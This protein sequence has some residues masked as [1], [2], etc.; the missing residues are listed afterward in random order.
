MVTEQRVFREDFLREIARRSRCCET[1]QARGWVRL[2][3]RTMHE[4]R[5]SVKSPIVHAQ[6]RG[7]TFWPQSLASAPDLITIGWVTSESYP[8]VTLRTVFGG[9]SRP[10][11]ILKP[12]PTPSPHRP[13]DVRRPPSSR[14]WRRSAPGSTLQ[15][16][17]LVFAFCSVVPSR[18]D[19]RKKV[20]RLRARHTESFPAVQRS[21][22]VPTDQGG[23]SAGQRL[24]DPL[25]PPCIVVCLDL[26]FFAS[27]GRRAYH[28]KKLWK[29]VVRKNVWEK[30]AMNK[31][32]A[33]KVIYDDSTLLHDDYMLLCDSCMSPPTIL[34]RPS[35][36][37]LSG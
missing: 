26:H 13:C 20:R 24:F 18:G 19:A 6:T 33:C 2:L 8:S 28:G 31:S 1:S 16:S 12:R 21:E 37:L 17:T 4:N 35:V 3:W 22:E 36:V 14:K 23:S 7:S 9:A 27:F 11:K 34:I 10:R 25:T 30:S 32:R 5:G 15:E 29:F